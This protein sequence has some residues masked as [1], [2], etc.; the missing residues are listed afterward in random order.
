MARS[1]GASVT[2][3]AIPLDLQRVL[4]FS[5][6]SSI[7]GNVEFNAVEASIS[8]HWGAC[9]ARALTGLNTNVLDH[10]GGWKIAGLSSPRC[11]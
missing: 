10:F 5:V 1:V 11:R 9:S 6:Q 8:A 4:L 2:K 3:L 7:S